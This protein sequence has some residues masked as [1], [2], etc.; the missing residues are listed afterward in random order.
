[1]G[2]SLFGGISKRVWEPVETCLRFSP[3][4]M[5][6]PFP[7]GRLFVSVGRLVALED[8]SRQYPIGALMDEP[9][10]ALDVHT[11]LRMEAEILNLW[12][13]TGKTVIFV[14][15]D[16][17]EAISLSDEV[18]VLSAGPESRLVGIYHVYQ[19]AN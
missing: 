8:G 7:P 3:A 15:H 4:S 14:T 12:A 6:S 19:A 9:F 11:R 17:A 10:S 1:M 13:E 18:A 16:L 5:L 2:I